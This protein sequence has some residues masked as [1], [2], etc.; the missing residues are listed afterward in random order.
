MLI[1]Y[2]AAKGGAGTSVLAAVH[3][4]AVAE[5]GP[6]LLVDL[7]GDLPDVLGVRHPD[8]GVA[9][10]LAAG[11]GVPSDALD[12]IAAPI[13]PNLSLL[14]R[15]RGRLAGP[16]LAVLAELLHR[17]PRIVVVDCGSSP[18][19]AGRAVAQAADRSILVTRPCYLAMRRQARLGLAPTEIA[20]VREKQRALRNDD[21]A[22]SV[23]APVR[24]S[25]DLDPNVARIVDAGLLTARLPRSLRRAVA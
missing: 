3:A 5:T 15:G 17:S 25:I 7:D 24:L 2:W 22:R 11:D 18:G 21:V 16:R 19:A 12:R 23:G 8:A 14:A 4:L 20:V 10:W 9:E 6:A 13:A 1:A